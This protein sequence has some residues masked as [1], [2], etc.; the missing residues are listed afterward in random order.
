MRNSSPGKWP[1][2]R[3]VVIWVPLDNQNV[4]RNHK[5]EQKG[6]KSM[7]TNMNV[8]CDHNNFLILIYKAKSYFGPT[9]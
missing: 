1:K 4:F 8:N 7:L 5:T 6:F 9:K 3:R 2:R